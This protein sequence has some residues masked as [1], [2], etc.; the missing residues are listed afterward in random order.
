[1]NKLA[2][3]PELAR[4]GSHLLGRSPEATAATEGAVRGAVGRLETGAKRL[5]NTPIPGTPELLPGKITGPL[6]KGVDFA[7]ENPETILGT[8]TPI[9]GGGMLA[10]A[11]KRALERGLSHLAPAPKLAF[12]ESAYSAGTGPFPAIRSGASSLPPPR[13]PRLGA[14][15][16]KAAFATSAYDAGPAPTWSHD[17]AAPSG[18]SSIPAFKAPRLDTAVQK[19]AELELDFFLLKI[20]ATN[21]GQW[22]EQVGGPHLAKGGSH[23]EFK[24]MMEKEGLPEGVQKKFM[25]V[26]AKK[27]PKGYNTRRGAASP[28]P[29]RPWQ[30]A[31]PP[32]WSTEDFNDFR[33][34]YHDATGGSGLKGHLNRNWPLYAVGALYAGGAYAAHR[35]HEEELRRRRE[36]AKKKREE[37]GHAP[38]QKAAAGAPTRGN[39]MMASDVPAFKAPRLDQAVQKDSAFE[40]EPYTSIFKGAKHVK[41]EG[42]AVIEA[43]K[44]GKSLGKGNLLKEKDSDALPE[45]MALQ[46]WDSFRR[47]NIN[48]KHAFDMSTEKMAEF[49]EG[50]LKEAIPGLTPQS[51]LEQSSSIGAP[52][53]NPPPAPGPSIADQAKPKGPGFGT[54]IAG[55]NKGSIG[56]T[57]VGGIGRMASPPQV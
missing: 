16:Q 4:A 57:S 35:S 45:G 3:L 21:V 20:A 37:E 5:L 7:I 32:H 53:A 10:H 30:G 9:P 12:S 39:F 33:R 6:R 11:G 27:Y 42:D 47:V 28:G 54:G 24:K 44:H 18:A 36:K 19:T 50:L 17:R 49:V 52:R 31:P 56:G 46:P 48:A 1:M 38:K 43:D 26:A 2:L 51:R 25:D 40:T 34:Q 8:A 55:A 23:E 14:A 22:W 41:L 13:A 29:K 15:I